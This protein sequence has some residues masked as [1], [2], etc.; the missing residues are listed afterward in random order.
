MSLDEVQYKY[1]LLENTNDLIN[2]DQVKDACRHDPTYRAFHKFKCPNCHK[3]MY[4]T[5]GALYVHHFRHNGDKCSPNGYLHS[6][7]ER[8]FLEEYNECL[9]KKEPFFVDIKVSRICNPKCVIHRNSCK[10][11]FVTKSLNLT[12]KYTK[13]SVEERVDFN[14]YYRRP[15]ILLES[16]NGEQLWIEFWVHHETED[17]KKKDAAIVEI[18]LKTEDD[19][20]PI[21]EHHIRNLKDLS[22]SLWDYQHVISKPEECEYFQTRINPS[23]IPLP[24]KYKPQKPTLSAAP[25]LE[26]VK[27]KWID[28][29]LPSGLLWADLDGKPEE[30]RDCMTLPAAEDIKELI[31]HC[32]QE[33]ENGKLLITGPNGSS[34]VFNTGLYRL[35]SHTLSHNGVDI[36]SV[37]SS[38]S[39]YLNLFDD[40]YSARHQFR[41]VMNRLNVI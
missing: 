2:I 18:R 21:K 40:D 33:I 20:L 30:C 29:G 11:L 4:A 41:Y 17:N 8:I 19:L 3:E 7:A 12:E 31:Q 15:D 9:R 10:E 13:I 37:F 22:V 28:L 24:P 34:I 16:E 32:K 5:L 39:G 25:V 35:S 27:V 23:Y 38:P 1:A 36:V 26:I 14:S 6:L